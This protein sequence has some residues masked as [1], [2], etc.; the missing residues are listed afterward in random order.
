[1]LESLKFDF[2]SGKDPATRLPIELR[3]NKDDFTELTGEKGSQLLKFVQ[4]KQ[5]QETKD[6]QAKI[7][8]SIKYQILCEETAMIGVIKQD[9]Q[10]T[11]E[12]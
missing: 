10:S 8:M 4:F 6:K 9:E 1:M 11:A 3:F 12:P 2:F 5:I 7:R